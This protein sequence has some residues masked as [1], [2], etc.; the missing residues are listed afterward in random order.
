MFLLE[1]SK[2][3]GDLVIVKIDGVELLLHSLHVLPVL[4]LHHLTHVLVLGLH[5]LDHQGYLCHPLLQPGLDLLVHR[6]PH[7]IGHHTQLGQSVCTLI[8]RLPQLHQ[9][10]VHMI[11]VVRHTG[12]DTGNG[13]LEAPDLVL[14]LLHLLLQ[15]VSV[16][17][18]RD[19]ALL[20][21]LL[22]HGQPRT[23]G[24]HHH[25]PALVGIVTFFQ[26]QHLVK[27]TLQFIIQL[28]DRR[29]L[30]I[31]LLAKIISKNL[32]RPFKP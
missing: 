16:P 12:P 2:S 31:M 22:H 18:V 7:L 17:G 1:I 29:F 27:S 9:C 8:G 25:H 19:I 5:L 32:Q 6:G 23:Q 3:L 20:L 26:Q 24:L 11:S 4:L 21:P 28:L 13:L 10:G 15:L 14:D 30:S